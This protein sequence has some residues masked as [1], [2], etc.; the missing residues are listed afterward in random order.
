V[1]DVRVALAGEE[2]ER[3]A[4][5]LAGAFV[6]EDLHGVFEGADVAFEFRAVVCPVS[7]AFDVFRVGD[8]AH[9]LLEPGTHEFAGPRDLVEREEDAQ[10]DDEHLTHGWEYNPGPW[11]CGIWEGVSPNPRGQ[12]VECR[13]SWIF[14]SYS[15]DPPLSPNSGFVGC[16]NDAP[17]RRRLPRCIVDA[18]YGFGVGL[19]HRDEPPL[20]PDFRREERG[21][22]LVLVDGVVPAFA[23]SA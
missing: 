12:S 18:P 9:D 19:A 10:Q 16:I 21:E 13:R 3:E 1:A 22:E 2:D 23:G 14:L 7:E 20:G 15:F 6:D 5:H 4:Q 8:P 11:G 17:R